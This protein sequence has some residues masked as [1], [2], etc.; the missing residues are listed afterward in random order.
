[1]MTKDEQ[2]V[3]ELFDRANHDEFVFRANKEKAEMFLSQNQNNKDRLL[4]VVKALEII[5]KKRVNIDE[6]QRSIDLD[7]YNKFAWT[8]IGTDYKLT[9]EEFNLLREMLE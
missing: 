4:K 2:A 9:Q 5:K 3:E 8:W 1:M 7:D 6:F